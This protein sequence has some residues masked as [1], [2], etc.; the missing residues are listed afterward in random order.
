MEIKKGIASKE[1]IILLGMILSKR[2]LKGVSPFFDSS[3]DCFASA[4]TKVVAKWCW[5]YYKKYDRPIVDNLKNIFEI[6][7]DNLND[8]AKK[9]IELFLTSV[10]D[11]YERVGKF[12]SGYALDIAEGYFK[13]RTIANLKTS[14]GKKL[15]TNDI[16]S[17]ED[18]IES[19]TSNIAMKTATWVNPLNIDI[20]KDAFDVESKETIMRMSGKFGEIIGDL[21]REFFVGILGK[22]GIGKTWMLL[23]FAMSALMKG[24]NVLFV[25]LE[26]SAKQLEKRMYH[27]L[28]GL[29]AEK[30]KGGHYIPVFDCLSNQNGTCRLPQRTNKRPLVIKGSKLESVEDNKKY[31]PCVACRHIEKK[32]EEKGKKK[33][34]IYYKPAT[35]FRFINKKAISSEVVI[36]R[37]D[38]ILS[39]NLLK[40]GKI[41]LL[42]YPSGTL[43][44]HELRRQVNLLTHYEG[45]I[46]DVIVTDY[47]DKFAAKSKE[48]HRF[49]LCEIWEGHK[50]LGQEF[51][52]LVVTGSQS[53][54]VRGEGDTKAY[55]WAEAA[56][57]LNLID[58]GIG[59]NQSLDEKKEGI[60]R[61]FIAKHRHDYFTTDRQVMILQAL[62]LGGMYLDSEYLNTKK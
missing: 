1:R 23:F 4:H 20:I 54:A 28:T 51:H 14:L 43:T 35:W 53:S 41:R 19:Y 6:E 8:D 33:K 37:V 59:F 11:E 38:N 10:S 22:S 36:K 27:F 57:K 34:I 55:D 44:I 49:Q 13:Y 29:P 18:M 7:K 39:C 9:N 21:E 50:A 61:A 60:L 15:A 30:D 26:L 5:D 62:K 2:F 52:S 16:Q 25:N 32:K 48:G 24:Y 46:P 47:A 31:L 17:A 40:G 12:N 58:L 3:K 56:F 42:S 45:Y